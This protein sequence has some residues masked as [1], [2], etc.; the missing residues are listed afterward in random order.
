MIPV[1]YCTFLK[2]VHHCFITYFLSSLYYATDGQKFETELFIFQEL[3][4]F[5][6]AILSHWFAKDI[7]FQSL[8]YA[9]SYP[10]SCKISLDYD[11]GQKILYV[12]N[13]ESV[14]E[15]GQEPLK[16]PEL[17]RQISIFD[18]MVYLWTYFF[19]SDPEQLALQSDHRKLIF[20]QSN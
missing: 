14:D 15:E 6:K 20:K 18:N 5:K 4:T 9:H 8:N 1:I 19:G 2:A 17:I 12:A 11:K 7:F 16:N 10:Y 13:R 3:K